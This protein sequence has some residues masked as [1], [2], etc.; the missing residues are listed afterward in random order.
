ML[1]P[2]PPSPHAPP[3]SRFRKEG[4]ASER[5]MVR[6]RNIPT[7]PSSPPSPLH[8]TSARPS[9]TVRNLRRRL[10]GTRHVA[11]CMVRFSFT[12]WFSTLL[13]VPQEGAANQCMVCFQQCKLPPSQPPTAPP[14]PSQGVGRGA[15]SRVVEMYIDTLEY[16]M[17]EMYI[18]WK[19]KD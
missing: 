19:T 16:C 15:I 9:G 14:P 8:L 12:I 18:L 2:P 7:M 6:S 4:T 13:S 5:G 3:P 11:G 1:T 17:E 10:Q